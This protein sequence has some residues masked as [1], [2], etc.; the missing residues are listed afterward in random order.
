MK[1]L[2]YRSVFL[3]LLSPEGRKSDDPIFIQ[4]LMSDI[5][6]FITA[7]NVIIKV[8]NDFF[9]INKLDSNEQI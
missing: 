3:S 8:L 1:A 9:R 2:P 4:S 6:C 7:I 5:E